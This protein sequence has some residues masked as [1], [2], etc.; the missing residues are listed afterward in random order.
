MYLCLCG[1]VTESS[2]RENVVSHS[3]NVKSH[4]FWMLKKNVKKTYL[5]SQATLITQPLIT[6]L[7]E[8]STGKSRYNYNENLNSATYSAARQRKLSLK[9]NIKYKVNI[10]VKF[11]K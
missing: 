1:D 8:V 7:P 11:R 10:G 5:V 3:K 4:V 9:C 2:V 6:P